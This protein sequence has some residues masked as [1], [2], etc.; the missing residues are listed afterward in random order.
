MSNKTDNTVNEDKVLDNKIKD[1]IDHIKNPKT[2]LTKEKLLELKRKTIDAMSIDRQKLVTKMPFTGGML[3]RMN[4]IPIRDYRCSTAMTDGKNIYVDIDFYK[5]LSKEERVFILA[6]ECWHNIYLH[7]MRCQ[8]RNRDLWNIATDCEINYML[9]NEGLVPPL[10]LC[11][12]DGEHGC[13]PSDYAGKSAEEMYEWLYK[14]AKKM[15]KN[16]NSGGGK[17][18]NDSGKGSTP[19]DGSNKSPRNGKLQGQFDK[20]ITDEE[21]NDENEGNGAGGLSEY[22]VPTDEWGEKGEDS[23]YRPM[24]DQDAAEKIREG[25]ISEAQKIERNQGRL[26]GGLQNILDKIR[27]PEINWKEMLSKYVS[28]CMSGGHRS[29]LP[30]SRR[31]VYEEMYFQSHRGEHIKVSVIVDTSGSTTADLPKFMGELVSL[32][33]TFGNYEM[34]MIQCDCEVQDVEIYDTYN[35]FPVEDCSKVKWKGFGGSDLNPAFNRM[36]EEGFE[37]SVNIVF[38]DGYID[39]PRNNPLPIQTLFVLTSDGNEKLADW[40]IKTKFKEKIENND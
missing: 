24:I 36:R 11:F 22:G 20:H 35:P 6:H 10:D 40:G 14:Q 16:G 28:T 13:P 2:S 3:M 18:K 26:P 31:H 15:S 19:T 25:I 30:P 21:T 34:M 23:D 7:F 39:C 9:K 38:T 37:P 12:P 1:F 8:N 33:N 29:W 32:L 5:K 17:G 4:F 27:N